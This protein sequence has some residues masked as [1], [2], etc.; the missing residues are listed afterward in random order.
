MTQKNENFLNEKN[1]RITKQ[2]HAFKSF[3]SSYNVHILNSFS[4]ELQIKDS[5]STIKS[6]LIDLLT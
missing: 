5:E 2:K 6:K 4:P 1:V 3:P